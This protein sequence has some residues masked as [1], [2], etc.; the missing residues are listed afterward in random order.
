MFQP[1]T[2]SDRE[3]PL[4]ARR[5]LEMA[6]S[7]RAYVRIPNGPDVWICGD[8]HVGNLAPIGHPEGRA[9]VELVAVHEGAYLEHCQRYAKPPKALAA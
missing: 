9:V 2:P 1:P 4:L 6:R 8:C 5:D 3:A 7:V